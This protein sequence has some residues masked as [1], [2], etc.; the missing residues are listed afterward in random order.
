MQLRKMR[1]YLVITFYSDMARECYIIYIRW[2]NDQIKELS[3][4]QISIFVFLLMWQN[5]H[6]QTRNLISKSCLNLRNAKKV[7]ILD[8]LK[9][10]IFRIVL[11]MADIWPILHNAL[12]PHSSLIWK[13]KLFAVSLQSFNGLKTYV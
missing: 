12:M 8:F 3:W 4:R 9:H 2:L 5:S 13:Q 11:L 7:V 6:F 10:K 1:L